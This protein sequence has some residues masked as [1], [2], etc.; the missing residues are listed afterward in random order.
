MIQQQEHH[1]A[2]WRMRFTS[3]AMGFSCLGRTVEISMQGVSFHSDFDIPLLS[4]SRVTIF[5]PPGDGYPQPY[6]FDA[7]TRAVSSVLQ[8]ESGFLIGLEFTDIHA[9]GATVLKIKLTSCPMVPGSEMT[10]SEAL[11]GAKAIV[12]EKK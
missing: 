12:A 4:A 8:G 11:K 7:D 9:D 2:W 10:V 1:Y 3:E 5:I 6:Q